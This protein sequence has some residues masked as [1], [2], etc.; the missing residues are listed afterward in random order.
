MPQM[1]GAETAAPG[2][3]PEPARTLRLANQTENPGNFPCMFAIQ[4]AGDAD[5]DV[6]VQVGTQGVGVAQSNAPTTGARDIFYFFPAQ[7]QTLAAIQGNWRVF[8]NGINADASRELL[9]SDMTLQANGDIASCDY[10]TETG[11]PQAFAPCT[12]YTEQTVSLTESAT[13]AGGFTIRW[14]GV[15]QGT[16]FAYRAQDGSFA[17]FGRINEAAL[18]GSPAPF[19]YAASI[20]AARPF[21]RTLPSVG[22]TDRYWDISISGAPLNP[23]ID[24]TPAANQ[25]TAVDAAAGTVT[26]VG[27][28]PPGSN[29]PTNGI[30]ST[31]RLNYPVNGLAYR[32]ADNAQDPPLAAMYQML[33]PTMGLS[34]SVNAD[35][36]N[37]KLTLSPMRP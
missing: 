8:E 20:V 5:V 15:S 26:R 22:R 19:N 1:T 11:D 32:A 27:L 36:G 14:D 21:T 16:L 24:S 13:F 29:P 33:M 25:V 2:A 4:N 31:T 34:I 18:P 3:P 35:P 7:R 9:F 37:Y 30:F 17:L 28:N 12:P 10:N 6:F 23:V